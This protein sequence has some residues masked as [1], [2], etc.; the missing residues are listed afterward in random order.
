MNKELQDLAWRCLPRE[1][2]EEVKNVTQRYSYRALALFGKER[3][4]ANKFYDDFINLFG[5]HNLTSDAEGEDEMLCVSRKDMQFYYQYYK[6]KRES[7]S[8]AE[9]KAY[10]KGRTKVF[11]DLFGSK[12][13]P[14]NVD[15]SEPN[16]DSLPQNPTENC[17]NKSHISA[18]CNKPAE[19]KFKV[20]DMAVVRGFKHPL[21]K[22]DGAIVT[23][24]SYHE[25]DDFYSCAIA[26][27]IGIVVAAKYLEPYTEP[28]NFGREVNFPTKNNLAI[29]LK[30]SKNCDNRLQIAAMAMQGILSNIDLFKN[31]LEAGM[32]TLSG[33]GFSY[34]AVAKASLLFADALIAEAEKRS[35]HGK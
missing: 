13:L 31:V 5:R 34:Q 4:L 30:K 21:L 1:F 20:G 8:S 2:R 19:P 27:N 26:P 6:T 7:E 9:Q 12:C 25:K 16:V 24:L 15:S 32:E 3:Q 23:I 18:D 10:Y 33:D 29:Y 11:L 35:G 14:D 28:T 17:D 22:S